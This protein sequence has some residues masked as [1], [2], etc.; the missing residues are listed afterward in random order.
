MLTLPP[1]ALPP[2]HKI[3]QRLSGRHGSSANSPAGARSPAPRSP[4]GPRSPASSV[5]GLTRVPAASQLPGSM[6]Q[7][8]SE[9]EE[10]S[11]VVGGPLQED[12]EFDA[13][14]AVGA[15]G[16]LGWPWQRRGPLWL[17]HWVHM[18]AWRTQYLAGVLAGSC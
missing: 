11:M 17:D 1:I 5:P 7:L 2:Q 10:G 3:L 4:S 6:L 15:P 13:H 16:L 8:L 18:E 14:L 9:V 12:V